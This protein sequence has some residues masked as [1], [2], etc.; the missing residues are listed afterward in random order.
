MLSIPTMRIAAILLV[1][2]TFGAAACGSSEAS[3]SGGAVD[4]GG[5]GDGGSS[6]G[7]GATPSNGEITLTSCTTTAADDVPAFYKAYF[8]CSAITL[9]GA[10]VVVRTKGLPP[11]KSYYWGTTSPN[12][13]PFDTS[14]G[15]D[16]R[17]NPNFLSEQNVTVRIP[18]TPV[19]K[20]GLTVT[21]ALVDG[22]AGG[23]NTSVDYPMGPAGVALNGV[24]LYN[25]LARPGDDIAQER[26]TFD[27]YNAHP[28]PRGAYHYHT[29]SKG[30]LAV[31]A[32]K[33]LTAS[34][35]PGAASVELYGV[36]C[37]G[38]LVMGC[39]ELDGAEPSKTDFDAQNGHTHDVRD[40]GGKDASLPGRYHVHIC[41]SWTDKPRPYT[42]EVQ[43]YDRCTVN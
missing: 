25:P 19:K 36:M 7:D 24:I 6:S 10:D 33:G 9:E 22:V 5:G 28:D 26:F 27:D 43:V 40:A 38:A 13:A 42:P 18:V 14:R 23:P 35:V 29:F 12:F 8:K 4:G 20:P 30:P 15:A 17:A 21:A 2:L 31:L 3:S 37:D 39:K 16:Y 32:A 11:Y 41:P 1:A 34:D